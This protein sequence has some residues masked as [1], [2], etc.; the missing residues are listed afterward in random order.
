MKHRH[1]IY[2]M[3]ALMMAIGIVATASGCGN[4][5]VMEVIPA[6]VET[7]LTVDRNTV[8]EQIE[9]LYQTLK[10]YE[11][12]IN[13]D[14]Y[15]LREPVLCDSV[16][17][18]HHYN[19]E[20]GFTQDQTD[21]IRKIVFFEDNEEMEH[22]FSLTFD[23][24]KDGIMVK[25]IITASLLATNDQL[26]VEEAQENT[27]RLV[28][29][30]SR[31][32]LSIYLE[33]GDYVFLI[34]P[35]SFRD[36]ELNSTLYVLYKDEHDDNVDNAERYH[37]FQYAN[38]FNEMNLGEK[39]VLNPTAIENYFIDISVINDRNFISLFYV[40][41]TNPVYVEYDP[42]KM[43]SAIEAGKQYQIYGTLQHIHEGIPYIISDYVSEF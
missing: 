14:Y 5:N 18:F 17:N 10:T 7:Q 16:D 42:E 37:Q 9:H 34:K 43:L 12:N 40:D 29:S 6:V 30:Y 35:N 28:N 3:T 1:L 23:A 27:D 19:I 13:C 25:D 20:C 22:S 38:A 11:S 4:K 21:D 32:N 15:V 31:D 39:V 8:P 2:S 33:N 41:G 26:S 36:A 24:T